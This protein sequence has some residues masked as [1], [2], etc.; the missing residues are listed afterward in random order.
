MKHRR[1]LLLGLALTLS[2][3]IVPAA[4]AHGGSRGSDHHDTNKGQRH[5]DQTRHGGTQGAVV[6]RPQP[7]LDPVARHQPVGLRWS[8]VQTRARARHYVYRWGCA[9]TNNVYLMGHAWGVSPLHD[10]YVCG[11]LHAA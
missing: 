9:G 1:I 6:R 7:R 5:V 11:R 2:L 8:A 3:V 4:S 10:A